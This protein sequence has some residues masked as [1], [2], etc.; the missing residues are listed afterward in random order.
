[1]RK[2]STGTRAVSFA[3]ALAL[4]GL[5]LAGCART[6]PEQRLRE[7]LAGLQASVEQRDPGAL[8][9]YLAKDFVGPDGLDREQARRMAQVLFLQHRD[10]GVRAGPQ[11]I[12]LRDGHATVR[13]TAALTGGSGRF[14]PDS[15]Q[16][17]EIESGWR[18]EDGDWHLTSIRWTP[19]LGPAP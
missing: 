2:S 16:L 7:T 19:A 17:Y 5:V 10:V 1:M 8:Q 6:P 3:L 4:F 11:E 14:L 15:A 9:G 12:V 18:E 13:F